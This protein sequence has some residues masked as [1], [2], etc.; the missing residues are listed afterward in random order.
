M[1]FVV[2]I[3]RDDGAALDGSLIE[4]VM[5]EILHGDPTN[6]G[7][8]LRERNGEPWCA[9][10][11]MRENKLSLDVS[12]ASPNAPRNAVNAMELGI[13]LAEQLGATATEDM[14]FTRLN[15]EAL[16]ELLNTDS[17]FSQELAR[18]W[19]S[20][21]ATVQT[22]L[23]APLEAPILGDMVS[24]FYAFMFAPK[25]G[26]FSSKKLNVLDLLATLGQSFTVHSQKGCHVL[27]HRE[28]GQGTVQLLELP[29]GELTVRPYW[30]NLPFKVLAQQTLGVVRRISEETKILPTHNG[31]HV[32]TAAL[33]EIESESTWA[34]DY[35]L[36]LQSREG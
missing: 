24:E 11:W 29:K 15:L 33:S 19:Q 17:E 31:R 27:E 3:E 36:W 12:W 16:D 14:S 9:V 6:K 34:M 28:L 4:E 18:M 13:K 8:I 22:E 25:R 26:F 20:T 5:D 1:T 2:N 21:R 7:W 32:D 35:L 10:F 30:S 23:R